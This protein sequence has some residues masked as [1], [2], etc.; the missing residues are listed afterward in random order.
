VTAP[1]NTRRDECMG[2]FYHGGFHNDRHALWFRNLSIGQILHGDSAPV[3][4]TI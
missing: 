3:R 4:D 2:G 1:K